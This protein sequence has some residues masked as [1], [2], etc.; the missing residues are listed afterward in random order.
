MRSLI[1]LAFS[2]LICSQL[3]IA[4]LRYDTLQWQNRPEL[5]D[6]LIEQINNSEVKSL[7]EIPDFVI[8][9]L[10]LG[11]LGPVREVVLKKQGVPYRKFVFDHQQRP[12]VDLSLDTSTYYTNCLAY[13]KKGLPILIG[14]P[15]IELSDDT[16]IHK[17]DKGVRKFWMEK[18]ARYLE[19]TTGSEKITSIEKYN[20]AGRIEELI[21]SS[22]DKAQWYRRKYIYDEDLLERLVDYGRVKG[23]EKKQ[24]ERIYTYGSDGMISMEAEGKRR[25]EYEHSFS[26]ASE[27][28]R[29]ITR[30][31]EQSNIALTQRIYD[32]Y[33][34]L[35]YQKSVSDTDSMVVEA[36][37]TYQ[38][39]EPLENDYRSLD[40]YIQRF[41]YNL[42]VGIDSLSKLTTGNG[43]RRT[44]EMSNQSKYKFLIST[45]ENRHV[46]SKYPYQSITNPQISII[47]VEPFF[48]NDKTIHY[49]LHYTETIELHFTNR[50]KLDKQLIR[51]R[52]F[53]RDSRIYEDYK[54]DL[55][56][57]IVSKDNYILVKQY[58]SDG[59]W[60]IS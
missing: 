36:V 13:D 7:S 42:H 9:D 45:I 46:V 17:S 41:Y 47:T 8:S 29:V 23:K 15:D 2:L 51:M 56:V 54:K 18:R 22:A 28:Y 4:Q 49:K 25:I 50:E 19:H 58:K 26:Y 6:A 21:E 11:Y 20:K 1:L 27:Y 33:N 3:S 35:V 12:I 44:L 14:R 43:H 40:D 24:S 16:L 32:K 38:R 52:S 30:Q 60:T 59:R 37:I 57:K 10:H 55:M 31:S 53:F 5:S 39:A 34:N 48:E